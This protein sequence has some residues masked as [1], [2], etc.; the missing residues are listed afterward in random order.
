MKFQVTTQADYDMGHWPFTIEAETPEAAA[1]QYDLNAC[2]YFCDDW[3]SH[4]G[5]AETIIV[6]D[7]DG[8]EVLRVET[9]YK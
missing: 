9:T 6:E 1:D 8:N 4:V 2:S 3:E 7:E 5:E